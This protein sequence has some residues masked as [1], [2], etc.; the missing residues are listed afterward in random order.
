MHERMNKCVS[1]NLYTC[2]WQPLATFPAKT[3]L[4]FF[5]ARLGYHGYRYRV[6]GLEKKKKYTNTAFNDHSD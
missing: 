6:D 3:H 4:Q 2:L 5:N 1:A